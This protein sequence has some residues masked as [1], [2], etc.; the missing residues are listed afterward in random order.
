MT[1]AAR[2]LDDFV[3]KITGNFALPIFFLNVNKL[4]LDKLFLNF[5][6]A[7]GDLSTLP[8]KLNACDWCIRHY[9][10]VDDGATFE[11][12]WSTETWARFNDWCDKQGISNPYTTDE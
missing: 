12:L 2:D 8:A 7:R 11:G 4:L 9:E 6:M 5:D 10:N 1:Q 3:I